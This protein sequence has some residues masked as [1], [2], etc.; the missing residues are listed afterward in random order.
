MPQSTVKVC[1]ICSLA[2]QVQKKD[3]SECWIDQ[4]IAG[5]KSSVVTGF[6]C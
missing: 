4:T 5:Q 3:L 6:M 2:E 1:L